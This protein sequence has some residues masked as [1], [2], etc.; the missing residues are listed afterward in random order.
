MLLKY[1]FVENEDSFIMCKKSISELLMSQ[2]HHGI[3][4][5]GIAL[6]LT[7]Y[8]G[9]SAKRIDTIDITGH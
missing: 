6:V 4:N 9:F 5:H 7:E 2:R 1:F 8:S 3:S